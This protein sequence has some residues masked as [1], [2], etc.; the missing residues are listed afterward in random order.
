MTASSAELAATADSARDQ[1]ERRS[2]ALTIARVASS[3]GELVVDVRV[4]NLAGHKLPTAYPSRRVWVHLAVHE[5]SGSVV[6]ES[7]AFTSDGSIFG[8]DN[9]ADGTRFEPHHRVIQRSDQVQIYEP[10]LGD[11]AGQVTTGLLALT[12]YLKD[13][14]LLPRGFE[15][16]AASHDIGVYGAAM[17]DDDF[18]GGEDEVRYRISLPG[19]VG[20]LVIAAELLYQPIGYRWAENLRAVPAAEARRFAGYYSAMSSASV[21]QISSARR[22]VP[23]PAD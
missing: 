5:A 3:K 22:T 15:K 6:F 14:R 16:R 7:G 8:N 1:L 9:D 18:R 23:P 4:E 19:R 2:G 10:I 11:S 12:R 21:V 17:G 13:N 20:R